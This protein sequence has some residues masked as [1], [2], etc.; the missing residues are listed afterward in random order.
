MKSTFNYQ[1]K[2]AM[3]RI[4]FDIIQADG[5]IAAREIFYFN[6]LKEE[7]DLSNDSRKDI[8]DKNSLLAMLQV[9]SFS[10]EQKKFFAKLMSDMIVVDED[11]DANEVAIYNVVQEYCGIENPFDENL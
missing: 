10:K 3:M 5:R 11:I 2:I 7:L 6:K 1:Q 8:T 9:R 4:L